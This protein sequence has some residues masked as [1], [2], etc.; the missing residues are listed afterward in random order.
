MRAPGD[1]SGQNPPNSCRFLP[2]NS[3]EGQRGM[4]WRVK[5]GYGGAFGGDNPFLT[6]IHALVTQI[7]SK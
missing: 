7:K 5:H 6:K 4:Q 3:R 1:L 2:L